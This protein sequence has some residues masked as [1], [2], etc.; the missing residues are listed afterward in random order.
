MYI[1]TLLSLSLCVNSWRCYTDTLFAWDFLIRVLCLYGSTHRARNLSQGRLCLKM[2]STIRKTRYVS[3]RDALPSHNNIAFRHKDSFVS[4][5]E[6]APWRH[7][8][9]HFSAV[10]PCR[11]HVGIP[12]SIAECGS[13]DQPRLLALRRLEIRSFSRHPDS[14][15]APSRLRLL[16]RPPRLS[17]HQGR[18]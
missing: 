14:T 7:L 5:R 4:Q 9:R 11:L 16:P 6:I 13:G 8:L 15:K 2:H 18:I 17:P 1:A 10:N 12:Y 3:W